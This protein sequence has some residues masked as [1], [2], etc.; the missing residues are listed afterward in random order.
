MENSYQFR[1]L[2]EDILYNA[3]E[4]ISEP[5]IEKTLSENTLYIRTMTSVCPTSFF[6]C[7]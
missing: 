2:N 5:E 7:C 6:T 4:E 1:E 3:I